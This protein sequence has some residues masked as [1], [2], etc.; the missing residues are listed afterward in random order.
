M[1]PGSNFGA[2]VTG[3]GKTKITV[4]WNYPGAGNQ[5]LSFLHREIP[6]RII[7]YDYFA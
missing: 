4:V 1:L 3:V 2:L 7:D 5:S 6:R